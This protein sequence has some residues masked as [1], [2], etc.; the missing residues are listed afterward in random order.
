LT[1]RTLGFS[2]RFDRHCAAVALMYVYRNL[3]H[4]QRNMRVSAAMAAG[5]TDHVWDLAEL[6]DVALAE[7][8]GE[9]PER[10]PLVIPRPE[11]PARE[12]P[13][14]RGWLGVVKG[15]E[16]AAPPAPP[17]AAPAVPAAASAAPEARPAPIVEV[18]PVL[19]AP[20]TAPH[21]L[22][23]VVRIAPV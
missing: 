14:D 12:L 5:I 10:K 18:P 23:P 13:G 20:N 16:P 11:G 8:D 17:P 21:V 19:P 4:V 15:G 9:K 6:M 2:K 3:C 7:P 1:R 22:A